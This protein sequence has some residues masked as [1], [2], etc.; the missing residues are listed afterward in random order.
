[1]VSSFCLIGETWP[2]G[3]GYSLTSAAHK[4]VLLPRLLFSSVKSFLR[5]TEL[6]L[7]AGLPSLRLLHDFSENNLWILHPS[8]NFPLIGD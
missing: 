3:G 6:S 7:G 4:P 1:M 2:C 8:I 5:S